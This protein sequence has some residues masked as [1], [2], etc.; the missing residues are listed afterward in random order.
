MGDDRNPRSLVFQVDR[1]REDLASL[2]D[3]GEVRRER[4]LLE[5]LAGRLPDIRDDHTLET[6]LQQ[7]DELLAGLVRSIGHTW[8]TPRPV[9]RDVASEAR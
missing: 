2:P 9:G 3:R 8:F 5:K 1:I 7:M 6:T 4:A